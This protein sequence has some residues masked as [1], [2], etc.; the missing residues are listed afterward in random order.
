MCRKERKKERKKGRKYLL[1]QARLPFWRVQIM[2]I[3]AK[4]A[5]APRAKNMDI[6]WEGGG[7]RRGCH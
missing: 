6:T 7:G 1:S 2:Y 5:V 3:P 4:I